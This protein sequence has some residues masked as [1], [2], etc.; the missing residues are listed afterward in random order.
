MIFTN[1]E[2]EIIEKHLKETMG[3]EFINKNGTTYVTMNKDYYIK[4][5]IDQRKSLQR[6]LDSVNDRIESLLKGERT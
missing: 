5:L 1:E 6:Q 3:L 2:R 4:S